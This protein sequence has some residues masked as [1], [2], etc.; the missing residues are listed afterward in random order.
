MLSALNMH[1]RDLRIKFIDETH[2][3]FVDGRG[4]YTSTTTF[5]KKFFEAFDA[6]VIL[7]KMRRTGSFKRKY[8][9][10]T[11]EQVKQAWEENRDNAARRGT[12]LHKYIEDF[13]N[14]EPWVNPPEELTYE[15]RLFE[16]FL[17]GE[18]AGLVPYRT[19]WYIFDE[20]LGIAGSIDMVFRRGNSYYIY[21]WKC[22]KEIR[23]R[24]FGKRGLG[25]AEFLEDCNYSHYS[26]QLNVYKY[27]LEK[28]YGL[29]IDELKLVVLHSSN[30]EPLI[31]PVKDLQQKLTQL[32]LDIKK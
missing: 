26:L 22:S 8:G 15:I 32:F 10:Q 4:G 21:D 28:N 12:A 16:D 23:Y 20:D 9:T 25:P 2:T 30:I 17:G 14:A 6:D 7:E 24:G 18:G 3:Y 13:Y 19:E 1:P 11:D 31:I 5:I 29:K 27:I